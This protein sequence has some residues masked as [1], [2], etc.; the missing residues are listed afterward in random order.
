MVIFDGFAIQVT[1]QHFQD[2]DDFAFRAWPTSDCQTV[3]GI[4]QSE[5]CTEF[6]QIL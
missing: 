1:P 5:T 2:K 4:L 6:W 3:M